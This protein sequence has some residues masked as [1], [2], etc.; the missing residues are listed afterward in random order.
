MLLPGMTA[1]E[2]LLTFDRAEAEA[3]AVVDS[4]IHRRMIGILTE[5][6]VLRR[7][8]GALEL[9]RQQMLGEK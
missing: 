3:L 6:A 1:R 8:T 7:Y 9:D 2:A 4:L 5:A